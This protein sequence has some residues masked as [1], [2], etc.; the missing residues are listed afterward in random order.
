MQGVIAIVSIGKSNS[1]HLK[2]LNG[3]PQGSILSPSLFN[4]FINDI[5]KLNLK[6]SLQLYA[7]DAVLTCFGKDI[8]RVAAEIE[9]DLEKID[10]WFIDNKLTINTDK[11]KFMTFKNQRMRNIN[12]NIH[13][14]DRRLEEVQEFNYLGLN[15]DN[16]LN[17]N[18]HIEKI[19]ASLSSTTFAI[20]RIKN[21]APTKI[22]CLMYNSY[23]LPK[24]QYLNAIW[25]NAA[26][27][28]MKDLQ[29]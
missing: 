15:I 23:F 24:L 8:Q 13:L 19:K 5:F 4:F 2:V 20:R 28:R 7:G 12:C 6:G 3:V 17:W 14:K 25:N 22:L 26:D 10:N 9:E 11:T 16:D 27:F 18:K 1:T 29:I 21:I